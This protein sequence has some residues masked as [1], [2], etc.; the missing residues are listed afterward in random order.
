MSTVSSTPNKRG[1]AGIDIHILK[2][3]KPRLREDVQ[4]KY[5]CDVPVLDF[6]THVWGI[7]QKV[8]QHILSQPWPSPKGPLE[9]YRVAKPESQ[10]YAPFADIADFWV[11]KARDVVADY[12]RQ[13][14]S[15]DLGA[16][17]AAQT[18]IHFW[19]DL[20]EQVLK[21]PLTTR[22]P[23]MLAVERE[24][25]QETPTWALVRQVIE[26][27]RK[28]Q[29]GEEFSATAS[30][31]SSAYDFSASVRGSSV[32]GSTSS[33]GFPILPE[34]PSASCEHHSVADAASP[35]SSLKRK[36]GG[37]SDSHDSKRLR[38]V[39]KVP[40]M[41]LDHLQLAIYALECMDASTRHYTSGLFIDRFQV[42]LWY[43]DR[44]CVISTV[45]FNFKRYPALLVL[46]LYALSACDNKHA[47]FDPYLITPPSVTRPEPVKE[48]KHWQDVVGSAI[49]LPPSEA[50]PGR[51]KF[52]IEDTLFAYR[53]LIGRGTMVY[54]VAPLFV[55]KCDPEALKVGWPLTTRTLEVETIEH[56]HSKLPPRWCEHIPEVT[57]SA[58]LTAK[59][60]QL[61][62]VELLKTNPID[63]FE[64][65]QMHALAMKLY[66]KLWEVGSVEAFQE[67]FIDCVECH[68]HAYEEGRVLHR[69]L[70]ENNL[71]FK[72]D[73]DSTVKGILNDWDMAS[74]VEDNDEIKLS[75]A[76]HRTGT[77]PF[78]A[79]DLLAPAGTD[80]PAHLY[81]HDLESFY[82]IL[83]WAAVHYDFAHK[84][85]VKR[86]EAL[87]AWDTDKFRVMQQVKE[88]FIGNR[89]QRDIVLK[90]IQ[91]GCEGLRPWLES[92]GKLFH[93]AH[94]VTEVNEELPGW[95]NNTLGGYITFA[96]FMSA[97]G[98]TPR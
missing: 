46:V 3:V 40:K 81:R 30:S 27:K 22:K 54:K 14:V 64:D 75:T 69:D 21:S 83:V 70:S 82:Y 88:S 96:T 44:S 1:V 91:P 55:G 19:N 76:T 51:G 57:F 42:S 87:D 20:G 13:Q 12:L 6:V 63:Q 11:E 47:G 48:N 73:K 10:M 50:Y 85:K 52:R 24:V 43:Y 31:N 95:D 78:M 23:D 9:A 65:R 67:V 62:R 18:M 97:L 80:P 56:L 35:A 77:I 29:V 84:E 41:T 66:G 71:M 59:D 5:S 28:S 15:D 33:L 58:T 2:Y 72:V 61:P 93:T 26:F 45:T 92:I 34:T 86:I 36:H 37:T 60:L 74:Y 79:R 17:T 38:T 4:A 16:N 49:H 94:L 39:P 8:A 89:K 7:D 32:A 25:V 68:Y 98:R 90:F 53:G